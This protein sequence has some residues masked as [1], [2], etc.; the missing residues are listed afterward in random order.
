MLFKQ[1]MVT[2]GSFDQLP[3]LLGQLPV[4][5]FLI[6]SLIAFLL[7]FLTGQTGSY[8]GIAFPIIVAAT[9]GQVSLPLAI[10]VFMAG[11]AGTMLSPMH[12]CLSLT[13]EY[14]K[15][16]LNKVLLMLVIPES[17]LVGTAILSYIILS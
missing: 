2:V 7:A 17:I 9:G 15:A 12:L 16:D 6:F 14:F 3:A 5:E 10:L 4:P 13:I 8:I 1:V 11:S